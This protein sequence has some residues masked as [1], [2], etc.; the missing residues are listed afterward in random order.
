MRSYILPLAVLATSVLAAPKPAWVNCETKGNTVIEYYETIVTDLVYVTE[1]AATPTYT[2]VTHTTSRKKHHHKSSSAAAYVAP[3]A[4]TVVTITGYETQAPA[5]TPTPVYNAPAP[6]S[7]PVEVQQPSYDGDLAKQVTD[8]HNFFRQLFDVADLE[9]DDTLASYAQ[10]HTGDCQMVHTGG[11]Y[12][13]NL[14]MGTSMTGVSGVQMW[15]NEAKGYDFGTNDWDENAGHLTQLL[16][17]TTEKVGCYLQNCGDQNYL[18]C[19]YSPAGNMLGSFSSGVPAPP[20]G[21]NV[22]DYCTS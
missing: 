20:A 6:S 19:E 15:F 8:K 11:P 4:P 13:E 16:W 18:M 3:A 21:L 5:T 22:D 1:G 9:W 2:P 10:A 17:K 14:A 7:T 12:G